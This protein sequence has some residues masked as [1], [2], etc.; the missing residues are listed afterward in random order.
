M[1]TP[2]TATTKKRFFFFFHIF[3][4]CQR[5]ERS[6]HERWFGSYSGQLSVVEAAESQ[7]GDLGDRDVAVVVGV[8]Q[9]EQFVVGGALSGREVQRSSGCGSS[10]GCACSLF[11]FA[12]QSADSGRTNERFNAAAAAAAVMVALVH[13][14]GSRGSKCRLRSYSISS[15]SDGGARRN[16]VAGSGMSNSYGTAWKRWMCSIDSNTSSRLR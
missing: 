15:L 8:G 12:R 10:H 5:L 7:K 1:P 13:F 16:V 4:F 14:L 11:G 2:T 3:F 9:L 6:R